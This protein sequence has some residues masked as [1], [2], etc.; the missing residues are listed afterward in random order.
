MKSETIKYKEPK[1][2]LSVN[3]NDLPEIKNW[4][5]GETYNVSATVKMVFQSEGDEYDMA[6]GDSKT[7]APIRGRFKV[8]SITGEKSKKGKQ[9]PRIRS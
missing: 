5:V 7:K 1:P 9:L 8:L 6:M 2:T 3:A 4:K